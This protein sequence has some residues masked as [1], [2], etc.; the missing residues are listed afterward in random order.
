[1]ANHGANSSGY[2][3]FYQGQHQQPPPSAMAALD[4]DDY[5]PFEMRAEQED[6]FTSPS[7]RAPHYPRATSNSTPDKPAAT[8][9]STSQQKVYTTATEIPALD[10]P[11]LEQ[12]H[13]RHHTGEKAS[14]SPSPLSKVTSNLRKRYSG[15]WAWYDLRYVFLPRYEPGTDPEAAALQQASQYDEAVKWEERKGGQ[16]VKGAD[17]RYEYRNEYYESDHK[18]IDTAVYLSPTNSVPRRLVVQATSDVLARVKAGAHTGDWIRTRINSDVPFMVTLSE[19]AL[20][21]LDKPQWWNKLD[22][23]LR[24]LAVSLPL[25]AMLVLPGFSGYDDDADIAD[26]YTD[27]PGYHCTSPRFGCD[28]PFVCACVRACVWPLLTFEIIVSRGLA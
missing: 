8:S 12:H 1:M 7:P 25:Q 2:N 24:V 9:S 11:A 4:T 19:W 20:R 23:G 16:V 13:H 14:S 26:S 6:K 5:D 27:H 3:N 18:F 21:P 28:A 15:R 17:G 10:T 22:A